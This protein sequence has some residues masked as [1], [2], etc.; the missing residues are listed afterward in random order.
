MVWDSATRAEI[1]PLPRLA[2]SRPRRATQPNAL[3]TLSEPS[4]RSRLSNSGTFAVYANVERK[5]A[6]FSIAS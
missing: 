1:E 4:Q 2:G 5:G 6:V 3:C